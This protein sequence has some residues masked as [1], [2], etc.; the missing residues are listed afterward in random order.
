MPP[1]SFLFI[2]HCVIVQ[3]VL[4]SSLDY[5]LSRSKERE[6]APLH[7]WGR[8]GL[9]GDRWWHR[10]PG[11]PSWSWWTTRWRSTP[12]TRS[13]VQLKGLLF[14]GSFF[15]EEKGGN[16]HFLFL[17]AALKANFAKTREANQS[18]TGTK[19]AEMF[20]SGFFLSFVTYLAPIGSRGEQ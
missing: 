11:C 4:F 17:P 6:Q 5:L 2:A 12:G 18:R 15:C 9:W 19:K 16:H 14:L 7:S 10:W 8:W 1:E 13:S 20:G 3:D